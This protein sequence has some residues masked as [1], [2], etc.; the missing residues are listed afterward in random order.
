VEF[1]KGIACACVETEPSINDRRLKEKL[2]LSGSGLVLWPIELS[3]M[4]PIHF[5]PQPSL[6]EGPGAVG[7]GA[8]QAHHIGGF[9]N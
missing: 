2:G 8:G 7:G 6:G 9:V 5:G 4:L 3:A 1:A